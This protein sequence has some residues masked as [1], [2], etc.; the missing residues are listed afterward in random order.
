MVVVVIN[1]ALIAFKGTAK[2]ILIDKAGAASVLFAGSLA[3]LR[4]FGLVN[5]LPPRSVTQLG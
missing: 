2:A 1:G 4:N 5:S 3:Y